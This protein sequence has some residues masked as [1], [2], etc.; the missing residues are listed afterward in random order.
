MERVNE[1]KEEV[2][3]EQE[4]EE[5]EEEEALASFSARVKHQKSRSL[6]PNP[7][8]T[9]ATQAIRNS[10]KQARLLRNDILHVILTLRCRSQLIVQIANFQ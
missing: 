10:A 7:T 2:E 1:G 5:E 8:E 4:E 6:L 3:E 9:L